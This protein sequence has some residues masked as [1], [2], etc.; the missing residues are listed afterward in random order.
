[1]SH[2]LRNSLVLGL[3]LLLEAAGAYYWIAVRQGDQLAQQAAQRADLKA[4]LEVIDAALA[5]YD[6]T[7]ARLD[8]LKARR[9]RQTQAL[10]ITDSPA[11]TLA[12]LNLLGER[13][14]RRLSFDLH[15][16]GQRPQDNYGEHV[17][18][19]E[20][21]GPFAHL[22]G[23]IEDLE[24]GPLFYT[25]DY[26]NL[27]SRAEQADSHGYG[28]VAFKLVLRSYF[29]GG[30]A[31]GQTPLQPVARTGQRPPDPFRPLIAHALPKNTLSLFEA[32][33]A[34]LT[35]LTHELAFFTDRRGNAHM[36]KVG[37]PIFLGRLA[38]ID[39]YQNEVEFVLNEGGI[40]R[41]IV[42]SLAA[43]DGRG[44]SW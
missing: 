15:F 28:G 16:T 34:L 11:R 42:L 40:R 14:Q 38:R 36:L 19:L 41:Q 21:E 8:S 23:F 10:A 20:G 5:I 44:A 27:E 13:R 39:I 9:Q 33:G 6:S 43:D 3:L 2:A 22:L 29:G 35:G 24:Y 7:A 37:D 17:Y 32:D 1:M 26:L 30:E 18:S 12:Y 25:V 31:P 4:H